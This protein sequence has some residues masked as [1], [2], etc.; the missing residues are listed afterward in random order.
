MP[1]L[2][3]LDFPL[4]IERLLGGKAV[5]FR[6]A[7]L[8]PVKHSGEG[9]RLGVSRFFSPEAGNEILQGH[10]PKVTQQKTLTQTREEDTKGGSAWY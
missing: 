2:R 4:G 6:A 3:N 1:L 8:V 7:A 9:Q 5:I 10:S